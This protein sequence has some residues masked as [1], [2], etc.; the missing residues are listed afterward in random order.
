MQPFNEARQK[1]HFC[2]QPLTI[3]ECKKKNKQRRNAR[4]QQQQKTSPRSN[5]RTTSKVKRIN[6]T[7]WHASRTKIKKQR[8]TSLTELR[9]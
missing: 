9:K 1:P 4:L 2:S 3:E 7:A 8:G 5:Q 6:P